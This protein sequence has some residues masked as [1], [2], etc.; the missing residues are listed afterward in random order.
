ML[1]KSKE[2]T[3]DVYLKLIDS[4]VKPIILY[5][6]ECWG[7]SL[8]KDCFANKIEKFYVSIYKQILGVKKNV[9]SMK[10]LAELGRTPL[11][12]NIEIQMFKYLQRFAFIEKERYVS[13]AFQEEN[14]A[15]DGWVKYMKTI[16]ELFWLGNLMGNICK[17]INGEIPKEKYRSKH[18]FFQKR[19]T[20]ID[21]EEKRSF[22]TELKQTYEKERYLNLKNFEIRNAL[23]KLRLSSNKLAVVTGKWY[24][25]NKEKRL[26]NFCNL[27]AIED[28]FH[29]LI[30]CP[31][32]KKLRKSPFKSIQDTE[33]I[34][35]SRGNITK[36]LK[37]C[38]QM[39][40]FDR[41]MY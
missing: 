24:K 33:H 39:D 23:S 10:I 1:H 29:F 15:I 19:A 26:C 13:K 3:I 18:K 4:L 25:I 37:N 22:F 7:D 38:S 32:Y 30:D 12:I 21:N 17:V 14:Q 16:L 28:E 2:K 6:C 20:D 27:N 34:D 40:C 35:L 36:K 9:S 11:K 5:A 8:K 31:N 41:Y